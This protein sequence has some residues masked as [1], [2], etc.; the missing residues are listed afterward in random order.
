MQSLITL[1]ID[2]VG[3]VAEV[4]DVT[5]RLYSHVIF[6]CGQLGSGLEMVKVQCHR[7]LHF[8]QLVHLGGCDQT[9]KF[10]GHCRCRSYS[11]SCS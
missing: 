4:V 1:K 7:L 8:L 10:V 6:L 9:M 11:G 5:A 3:S 2:G